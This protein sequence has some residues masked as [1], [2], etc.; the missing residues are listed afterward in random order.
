MSAVVA[1]E[2]M[3]QDDVEFDSD[4]SGWATSKV[5]HMA[6]MFENAASF[7]NDLSNWCVFLIASEPDSFGNPGLD[8][9]W[10]SCP[11]SVCGPGE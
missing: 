4:V 7:S 2:F 3:F 6:S 9:P 8:P 10:G 5:T 11:G 1:M